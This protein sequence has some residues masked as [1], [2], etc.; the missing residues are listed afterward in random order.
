MA[1]N[2]AGLTELYRDYLADA[3]GAVRF[4]Q[5]QSSGRTSPMK[6]VKKHIAS[7]AA[8]SFSALKWL[9][10]MHP[11]SRNPHARPVRMSELHW[12]V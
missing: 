8:V 10:C 12:M 7:R 11:Y 4:M 6:S 3:W 5:K 1:G 2:R 9:R